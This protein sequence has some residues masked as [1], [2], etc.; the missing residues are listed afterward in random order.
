MHLRGLSPLA[1]SVA[2]M[3]IM[4][5]VGSSSWECGRMYETGWPNRGMISN[6]LLYN[7]NSL[8]PVNPKTVAALELFSNS[9]PGASLLLRRH[10]LSRGSVG[11]LHA[12]LEQSSLF[13]QPPGG[14]D[15]PFWCRHT[16]VRPVQR[17]A[18]GCEGPRRVPGGQGTDA[19]DVTR[20]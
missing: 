12:H 20:E 7:P 11:R 13:D 4:A 8:S 19:E 2:I 9:E 17:E 1:V 5:R 16:A 14:D 18:D 15:R 3:H 10:H 6:S